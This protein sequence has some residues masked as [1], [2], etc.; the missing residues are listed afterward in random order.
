M[1]GRSTG[2]TGA[3]SRGR[4]RPTAS[5]AYRGGV[6]GGGGGDNDA[7][8]DYVGEGSESDGAEEEEEEE[9]EEERE[10]GGESEEDG[11]ACGPAR[12]G[13][14]A[15]LARSGRGPA[16]RRG[17]PA[18]SVAPK[19][20]PSLVRTSGEL[21]YRCGELQSRIAGPC[22]GAARGS[23]AA[24]WSAML[25]GFQELLGDGGPSV[26]MDGKRRHDLS[27]KDLGLARDCHKRLVDH[28][29]KEL[30]HRRR[31]VDRACEL[32]LEGL[33]LR[34]QATR[35][36][37]VDRLRS[38]EGELLRSCAQ[39]AALV[40]RECSAIDERVAADGVAAARAAAELQRTLR[41]EEFALHL[42]H[43]TG[44][45]VQMR[46]LSHEHAQFLRCRRAAA[47]NVRADFFG[48]DSAY[49]GLEVLEVFKVENTP[50]LKAFQRRAAK[51]RA[52]SV[53]GLFCAVPEATIP[54]LVV[55]GMT[56]DAPAAG[57]S[58]CWAADT[59][60]GSSS[61]SRSSSEESGAAQAAVQGQAAGCDD[62]FGAALFSRAQYTP[63]ELQGPGLAEKAFAAAPP[64]PFPAVFSR[65]STLESDRV[66]MSRSPRCNDDAAPQCVAL[67][68]VI[69]GEV[70]TTSHD[71]SGFPGATNAAAK[72]DSMLNPAQE[73]YLLLNRAFAL[74]EFLIRFR[75]QSRRSAGAAPAALPPPDKVLSTDLSTPAV[76]LL[77][78]AGP[79]RRLASLLPV[80]LGVP[81]DGDNLAQADQVGLRARER[82]VV[83][84]A[85]VAA[86]REGLHA[87]GD[88][89][90]E[91]MWKHVAQLLRSSRASAS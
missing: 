71:Y 87:N 49:T 77:P 56:V 91:T 76:Q 80:T 31:E 8:E 39:Y 4:P 54:R 13:A 25:G 1:A 73:E 10:N 30:A 86:S 5:S 2:F 27:E 53:K 34:F 33:D 37:A 41:L 75:Y 16:K 36:A 89:Q 59:A 35:W 9:E 78:P 45:Q 57:S 72:F 43:E 17:P 7:E 21:L 40:E 28:R 23:Y 68:R 46:R 3:R 60:T 55:A 38:L 12:G 62:A 6:V 52:G 83:Q 22:G 48:P 85:E 29:S 84:A 90:R 74:P 32:R 47:E 51:L 79:P 14:A 61:S 69:I 67:C 20:A 58:D 81:G 63:A 82:A 42:A 50:M 24:E 88:K 44:G 64:V 70:F 66:C 26:A 11:G 19:V 18:E 65:F 15:S